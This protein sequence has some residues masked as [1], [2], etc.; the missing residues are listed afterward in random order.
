MRTRLFGVCLLALVAA[1]PALA[2]DS[3]TSSI[4]GTVV[5]TGGGV[6]PGATVVAT[7]DSGVKFQALTNGNG[8][9]TIPAVTAGT[10]KVTVSL[11]GFKTAEV[12]NVRVV[13]NVP[14]SL[15]VKLEVGTLQET[16]TVESNSLV[17]TTTPTVSSTLNADELLR[18]PMTTRN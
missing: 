4:A 18:M 17:N 5:D 16:I 7:S 15:Q 12:T 2:Q 8:V 3:A 9:F 11:S 10:Y 1:S 6:I 14:T 13:P